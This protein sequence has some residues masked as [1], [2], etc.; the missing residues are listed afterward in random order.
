MSKEKFQIAA[1]GHVH[2]ADKVTGEVLLDKDNAIHNRNMAIAIARGLANDLP[3][4]ATRNHHVYKLKL[5]N[6]GT[7]LDSLNVLVYQPPNVE[8]MAATLYN[9]TY[10]EIVDDGDVAVP[11]A[12]AVTYQESPYPDITSL[13]I[14]TAT[15]AAGEPDGQ[16]LTDSEETDPESNFAFDELGLFTSDDLMLSHIIFSPIL[17]TANRELVITYTLTISVS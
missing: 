8:A 10:N 4:N 14:V 1:R 9:E 7:S 5:G 3:G 17:K 13:V 11:A 6:G 12:N 16:P 15:L 2:I